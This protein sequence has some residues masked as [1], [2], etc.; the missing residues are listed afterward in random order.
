MPAT[1]IKGTLR[2]RTQFYTRVLCQ[3][4]VG[5]EETLAT[6]LV[7]HLFGTEEGEQGIPGAVYISE[8]VFSK[9]TSFRVMQH[10]ALDRFTQG[11]LRSA[12]FGEVLLELADQPFEVSIVVDWN[13]LQTRRKNNDLQV[14][15]TAFEH[16]LD[17]LV[18]GCL[19]LGAAGSRGHGKVD[20]TWTA[21]STEAGA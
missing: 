11:P 19:S 5:S 2:H 9:D 3:E 6:E 4:W 17:D 13:L 21:Q 12:L 15:R 18:K 14:M 7:N 10:V 1:S 8:P 20:G 16:A